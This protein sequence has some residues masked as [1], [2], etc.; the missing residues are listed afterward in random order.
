MLTFMKN[1]KKFLDLKSDNEKFHALHYVDGRV[2]AASWH[3]MTWFDGDF[4]KHGSY[5]F[6]TGAELMDQTSP[7]PKVVP[8][9]KENSVY[10]VYS[11]AELEELHVFLKGIATMSVKKKDALSVQIEWEPV[12]MAF[13]VHEPKLQAQYAAS[14]YMRNHPHDEHERACVNVKYLADIVGYFAQRKTEARIYAPL[15][16]SRQTPI[17]F[18]AEETGAVLCQ[19]RDMTIFKD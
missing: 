11:P 4:G 12:I 2:Y 7:F 3:M 14:S 15:R 8:P 16:V 13:K 17:L 18:T 1:V 10:A 6:T 19:R 9:V 5:D